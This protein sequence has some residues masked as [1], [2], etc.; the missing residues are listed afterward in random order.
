MK[1]SLFKLLFSTIFLPYIFTGYAMD[2]WH[3]F[4]A[5]TYTFPQGESLLE[6]L[7]FDVFI[8]CAFEQSDDYQ[9]IYQ[10]I[11]SINKLAQVSKKTN[12]HTSDTRMQEYRKK[13]IILLDANN[14]ENDRELLLIKAIRLE[15]YN[16]IN[17]LLKTGAYAGQT[18]LLKTSNY[19]R[20]PFIYTLWTK[21]SGKRYKKIINQLIDAYDSQ[22]QIL[23]YKYLLD[24]SEFRA[25][26]DAP[27]V[28]QARN[29]VASR[30]GI[31]ER[32]KAWIEE[33]I[34]F[35]YDYFMEKIYEEK[36]S[37]P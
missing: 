4:I 25:F 33:E 35:F 11:Q 30:L 18:K 2:S 36:Q 31:Y 3:A 6:Q 17:Y 15:N 14:I 24:L 7:P 12:Q 8:Q 27:R 21:G 9:K 32:Y 20:H 5:P 19:R 37:T 28:V 34:A 23:I 10:A 16:H 1:N 22:E 26:Y 13:L 29:I